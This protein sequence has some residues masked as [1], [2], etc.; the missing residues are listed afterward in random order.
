[1]SR[2][3]SV[4]AAVRASVSVAQYLG[5]RHT[6][7]P[8]RTRTERAHGYSYSYDRIVANV[9]KAVFPAPRAARSAASKAG[10]FAFAGLEHY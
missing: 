9:V 10:G 8:D 7:N 2:G 3:A 5:P 4:R 1:V 6:F